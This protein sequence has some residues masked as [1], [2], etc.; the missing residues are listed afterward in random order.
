[1]YDKD[2]NGLQSLKY[3]LPGPLQ[4]GFAS[5]V[6]IGV[7]K[8]DVTSGEEVSF[9]AGNTYLLWVWFLLGRDVRPLF[10]LPYQVL[11]GVSYLHQCVK[12]MDKTGIRW[13]AH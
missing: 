6:L 11:V 4:E 3:L 5:P 12:I 1:M 7:K 10:K 13:A 8:P 9:W 2:V